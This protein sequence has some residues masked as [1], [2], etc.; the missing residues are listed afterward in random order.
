MLSDFG[1]TH[2][3][4]PPWIAVWPRGA[5]SLTIFGFNMLG[6]ALHDVLDP[7]RRGQ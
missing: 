4:R 7:R 1:R 5:I 3:L 6:D 2:M